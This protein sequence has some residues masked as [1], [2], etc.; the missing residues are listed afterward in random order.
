LWRNDAESKEKNL[1]N[2]ENN[3]S[4]LGIYIPGPEIYIPRL[5]TSNP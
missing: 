1:C 3:I 2:V 5:E 4:G